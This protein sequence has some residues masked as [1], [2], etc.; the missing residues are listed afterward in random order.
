M[1]T[2][3]LNERERKRYAESCRMISKTALCLA[4]ALEAN[5]DTKMVV[6]FMVFSLATASLAELQKVI[7]ESVRKDAPAPTDFLTP[8]ESARRL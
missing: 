6:E 3:D 4:E 2:T 1:I 5:D 8:E 7:V